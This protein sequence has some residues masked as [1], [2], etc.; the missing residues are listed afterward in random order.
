MGRGFEGWV[1]TV[2]HHVHHIAIRGADEE[3][4]ELEWVLRGVYGQAP[5]DVCRVFQHLPSL[6]HVEIENRA[7]VER[8]RGDQ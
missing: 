3:P 7:S 4:A 2:A 5:K 6:P 1:V 8:A